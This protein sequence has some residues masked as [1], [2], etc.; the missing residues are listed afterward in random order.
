MHYLR[1]TYQIYNKQ[2]WLLL[3]VVQ[4]SLQQVKMM[5]FQPGYFIKVA[6]PYTN[7]LK[8]LKLKITKFNFLNTLI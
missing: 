1:V 7:D 5:L 8:S 2:N 3:L 4:L 6:I